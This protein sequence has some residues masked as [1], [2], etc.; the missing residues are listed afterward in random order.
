MVTGVALV[1]MGLAGCDSGGEP[2]E[3]AKDIPASAEKSPKQVPVPAPSVLGQKSSDGG[4]DQLSAMLL[5]GRLSDE[6]LEILE[7][8]V[9]QNPAGAAEWAVTLPP[10]ADRD[11]CLETVFYNWGWEDSTAALNFIRGTLRGMDRTL[12][13]AS[14]A[15]AMAEESPESASAALALVAE[16]IPRGIV[17]ESIVTSGLA[18]SPDRT[19][20][21]AQALSNP[22]ERETALA[23]LASA[24]SEENPQACAAWLASNLNGD[25]R[26][27]A[28][29]ELMAN[30]GSTSPR[31]AAQWLAGQRNAAG[32]IDAGDE[33]ADAW[34]IVDPRAAAKWALQETD[35]AAREVFLETVVMNWVLNEAAETINWANQLQNP[36]LRKAALDSAFFSLEDESPAALDYWLESN[37]AHPAREAALKIRETE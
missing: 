12:A 31:E 16:P 28:A 30:W 21:W 2:A 19:A 5:R 10:G 9:E 29:V 7:E 14:V 26:V 36:E 22:Y 33:L 35:P 34:A 17:I 20:S 23:A 11:T 15:E 25:E 18:A 1:G 4:L 27:D 8:A 13:A 3:K 32:Y 6:G 24:W 37:P